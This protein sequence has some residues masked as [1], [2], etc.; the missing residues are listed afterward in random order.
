MHIADTYCTYG[1]SIFS[2]ACRLENDRH[3][4][5][6]YFTGPSEEERGE[7]NETGARSHPWNALK[8]LRRLP[9]NPSKLASTL[10][11][12]FRRTS[13]TYHSRRP[14]SVPIIPSPLL[15]S[16]LKSSFQY[17]FA[18]LWP[19]LRL[20]QVVLFVRLERVP[21]RPWACVNPDWLHAIGTTRHERLSTHV[22]QRRAPA[23]GT[24]STATMRRLAAE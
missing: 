6:R 2:L 20:W 16:I 11:T 1:R 18:A 15:F 19:R 4:S 5:C 13:P 24:P 7:R 9:R 23:A 17:S 10:A 22:D 12:N 14:R 21:V 3:S 8:P